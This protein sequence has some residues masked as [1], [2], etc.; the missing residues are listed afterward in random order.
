MSERM[1]DTG[2]KEYRID[3]GELQTR[4]TQYTTRRATQRRGIVGAA[5]TVLAGAREACDE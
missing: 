2:L 5:G 1:F 3:N 4:A